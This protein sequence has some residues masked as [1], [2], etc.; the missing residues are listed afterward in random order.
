M[1]SSVPTSLSG[2]GVAVELSM[3][4]SFSATSPADDVTSLSGLAVA[5]NSSGEVGAGDGSVVS[6][7]VTTDLTGEASD[8][9]TVQDVDASPDVVNEVASADAA[10]STVEV[11]D[12]GDESRAEPQTETDEVAS[13]DAA[14]STVE[15]QDEGD[16]SSAEPQAETRRLLQRELRRLVQMEKATVLPITTIL[17]TQ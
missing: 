10:E 2:E 12:E 11:Q 15:V 3:D 8:G 16:E 17:E 4:S 9:A 6:N 7:A 5:T 14:E 13:A 1:T